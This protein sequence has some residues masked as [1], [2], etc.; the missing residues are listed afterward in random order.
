MSPNANLVLADHARKSQTIFLQMSRHKLVKNLDLDEELDDFD[1]GVTEGDEEEL[2][3][4]DKG[5]TE[6]ENILAE[7]DN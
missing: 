4:E 7:A 6:H 5:S 3:E 1:G 2:T